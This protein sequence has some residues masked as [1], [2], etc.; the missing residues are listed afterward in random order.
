MQDLDLWHKCGHMTIASN[1][2]KMTI[3]QIVISDTIQDL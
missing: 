3:S 2:M 1:A